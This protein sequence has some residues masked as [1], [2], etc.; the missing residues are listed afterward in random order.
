[1]SDLV[2]ELNESNFDEVVLKAD[3]P[4]LVDFWAPWCGP[5][6]QM[7]PVVEQLAEIVGD[8]AI[9]AKVN[10]EENPVLQARYGANAIPMFLI[11]NQG[12]VVK[13]IVGAR[14]KAQLLAPL[15]EFMA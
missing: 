1:M 11:F 12:E 7:A 5:C 10:V 15:E 14:P 9:I 13:G 3:K 8:K 2:Q 4:V 6:R